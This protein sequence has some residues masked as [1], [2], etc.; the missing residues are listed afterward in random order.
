MKRSIALN[1]KQCLRRQPCAVCE[2]S[3]FRAPSGAEGRYRGVLFDTPT[4]TQRARWIRLLRGR[5]GYCYLE[6]EVDTTTQR[7]CFAGSRTRTRTTAIAPPRICAA[8]NHSATGCARRGCCTTS[9]IDCAS[10][11]RRGRPGDRPRVPQRGHESRRGS[12]AHFRCS[13]RRG[14]RV[15]SLHSACPDSTGRRRRNPS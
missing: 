8:R 9:V 2:L 13:D 4:A 11:I 10:F 1:L 14:L 15:P 12:D 5:D 7:A 3:T 6:H